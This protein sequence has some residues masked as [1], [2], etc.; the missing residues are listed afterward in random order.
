V[1]HLIGYNY[2]IL[3]HED[4]L[5]RWYASI[6]N[7]VV[8]SLRT[9][10]AFACLA[11]TFKWPLSVLFSCYPGYWPLRKLATA[12]INASSPSIDSEDESA[13]LLPSASSSSSTHIE[14]PALPHIKPMHSEPPAVPPPAKGIRSPIDFWQK[15]MKLTPYLWPKGDTYLKVLTASCMV[16]FFV[17]RITGILVPIYYKRLIDVLEKLQG[18]GTDDSSKID[19]IWEGLSEVVIFVLLRLLQ[20]SGGLL[21]TSHEML[22]LPVAQVVFQGLFI[23]ICI[24]ILLSSI[25]LDRYQWVCL[26]IYTSLFPLFRVYEL[27]NRNTLQSIPPVPCTTKDG[28]DSS[29]SR[30]FSYLTLHVPKLNVY[31]ITRKGRLEYCVSHNLNLLQRH[32]YLS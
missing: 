24:L 14:T 2:A 21:R 23:D 20:G 11:L 26:N 19:V 6:L 4:P 10:A 9:L 31:S 32:P 18:D 15:V 1:A 29:C 30:S 16:L 17:G 13:S 28:G 27:S 3:V 5:L 22:W 12:G 8:I 7:V 25:Q